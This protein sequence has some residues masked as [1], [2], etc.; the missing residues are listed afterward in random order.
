M[1][2]FVEPLGHVITLRG[3]I[4]VSRT[5]DDPPSPSPVCTFKTYTRGFS[6]CHP[7]Q[8]QPQPHTTTT[9]TTTQDVNDN[10]DDT[11]RQRRQ[12]QPTCSF[13]RLN[14]EKPTRSRH[15]K[16]YTDSFFLML[17][18]CMV[19]S[20]GEVFCLVTPFNDRDLRLLNHVMY[21]SYLITS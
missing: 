14:T 20:V 21:D 7:T 13:I 16:D 12:R 9:M 4:L 1:G 8:P 19:F 11:Q 10:D 5:D 6:A 17:W 3:Q 18:W 15:S 2:F